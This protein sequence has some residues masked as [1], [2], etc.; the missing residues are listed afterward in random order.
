MAKKKLLFYQAFV[1]LGTGI[2]LQK[3]PAVIKGIIN[4]L[5]IR[6]TYKLTDIEI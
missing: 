6:F 1:K 5:K 2:K 3:F 4:S